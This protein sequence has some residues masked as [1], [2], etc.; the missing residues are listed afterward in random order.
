MEHGLSKVAR[1]VVCELGPL[2]LMAPVDALGE[3]GQLDQAVAKYG[4]V[5]GDIR[6]ALVY[7]SSNPMNLVVGLLAKELRDFSG[8]LLAVLQPRQRVVGLA[9]GPHRSLG[10]VVMVVTAGSFFEKRAE[11]AT[12]PVHKELAM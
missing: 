11:V 3:A 2:S 4:R 6:A 9:A 12:G 1:D 10:S 8:N 5:Q 7:G